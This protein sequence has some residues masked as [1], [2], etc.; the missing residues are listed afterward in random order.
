MGG[1][2]PE[3]RTLFYRLI[4]LVSLCI[5][6]LFVF[7]GPNKPPFKRGSKVNPNAAAYFYKNTKD[8]LSLFGF[9]IHLAPGEAEAECAV[10]QK[11]GIVDAVLSEDVDTLM[12]GCDMHMRNWS[13]A[14]TK[15]KTPTHVDL[16]RA[17]ATKAKSGLDP[18]GMTLVAM[19]SGGDYLPGG[20]KG[21]GVKTACEAAR[22]GF[23]RELCKLSKHDDEAFA[24]W[25]DWLRHE[26]NT[27]E[28]GYFER[29]KKA[30]QI[31]D[32]FPNKTVLSYYTH[33]AISSTE[34]LELISQKLRWDEEVNI[35]QLRLFVA[36]MFDWDSLSGAIKLLRVLAPALL[37]RQLRKRASL[38]YVDLARQELEEKRLIKTIEGRREHF[39]TSGTPELRIGFVP[40]DIVKLNLDEERVIPDRE[41]SADSD[42]DE[43][44]SDSGS[45]NVLRSPRKP[46]VSPPYDPSQVQRLWVLETFVKIGV[47]LT[48]ETWEE[49][50]RE[51]KLTTSKAKGAAATSKISRPKPKATTGGMKRGALEGFVKTSKPGVSRSPAKP[52]VSRE[53]SQD[54]GGHT[55][56]GLDSSVTRNSGLKLAGKERANKDG[57]KKSTSTSSRRTAGVVTTSVSTKTSTNDSENPWT[58]SKRPLDTFNV[59]LPPGTRYSALGIYSSDDVPSPKLTDPD[60]AGLELDLVNASLPESPSKTKKHAR[61]ISNSSLDEPNRLG[62]RRKPYIGDDN[63]VARKEIIDLDTTTA[64][65]SETTGSTQQSKHQQTLRSQVVSPQNHATPRTNRRIRQDDHEPSNDSF[66]PTAQNPNRVLSFKQSS[67]PPASPAPSLD[68]LPSPSQLFS[69]KTTQETRHSSISSTPTKV[70]R[71]PKGLIMVR[72]SLP[73]AWRDVKPEEAAAKANKVMTSVEVVDL[74]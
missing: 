13:S 32:S 62:A 45:R 69:P 39:D 37:I 72:D 63:A 55:K 24:Q 52:I 7:D 35:P 9:P 43:H 33:P 61:P 19:M 70:S 18:E 28:S 20:I 59:K 60:Q 11:N 44:G 17:E 57:G 26:A 65:E 47:P 4:R 71:K 67:A 49:K 23:G 27:N 58:K 38:S 66:D 21:C 73:G 25:R 40:A 29:S 64:D 51:P 2:N 15:N 42:S 74:T 6:P 31:P 30:L 8:L 10:L 56:K 68:S 22:A 46:R 3:L 34:E 48:A 16:Y 41:M 54:D 50:L 36:E 1:K 5:E 14:G 53:K 12:F